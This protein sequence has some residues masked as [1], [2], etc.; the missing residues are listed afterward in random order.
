MR[1]HELAG[2][3][4]DPHNFPPATLKALRNHAEIF[5]HSDRFLLLTPEKSASS[6]L[7]SGANVEMLLNLLPQ[8][9]R[10][11]HE[12]L[13]KVEL[14]EDKRKAQYNAIKDWINSC[15]QFLLKQD[16]LIKETNESH[17]TLVA[18]RGEQ[19]GTEQ[20]GQPIQKP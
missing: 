5:D 4:P 1:A 13:G 2:P 3:I 20:Q 12:K 10:M 18:G 17:V 14:D 16:T 15:K 8:Q 19:Q 6:T 7:T 9:V 11:T